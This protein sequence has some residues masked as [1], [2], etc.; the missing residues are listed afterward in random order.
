ML[1][2]KR[3]G[4]QSS[5]ATDGETRAVVKGSRRMA[6]KPH[7]PNGMPRRENSLFQ[8]TLREHGKRSQL[9]EAL[10]LVHSTTVWGAQEIAA[11]GKL[12]T[13]HCDVFERELLYFFVMRPAYRSRFAGT[14]SHQLSRFPVAI[15]LPPQGLSPPFHVY[16]FDTGGAA[17]G[18]FASQAD[19]QIPLEDY[20]LR[21]DLEAASAHIEWAFET[22]ENFKP[23]ILNGVEEHDIVTRGYTDVAKMGRK[24]SND[25]DRRSSAVEVAFSGDVQLASGNGLIVF[26]RQMLEDKA[27]IDKFKSFGFKVEAYDWRAN[28]LPDEYTDDITDLAEEWYKENGWIK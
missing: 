6:R 11:A 17:K 10:P 27:L 14:A 28:T 19:P 7:F 1:A 16:P 12:I 26:P 15:I 24:A 21:E 4:M 5:A 25:F 13:R 23:D 20:A 9:P 2:C 3:C 22:I 8:R 18:A